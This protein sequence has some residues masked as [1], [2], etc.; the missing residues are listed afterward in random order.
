MNATLNIILTRFRQFVDNHHILQRFSFGQIDTVDLEKFGTYPLLHVVPGQENIDTVCTWSLDI[1][2]LDKPR[3]KDQHSK[4]DYQKHVLSDTAQCMRDLIAEITNGGNVFSFDENWSINVAV[5]AQYITQAFN[6]TLSG[7]FATVEINYPW[8]IDACDLPMT[9]VTPADLDCDDAIVTV[10][11]DAFGSVPSGGTLDVPVEYGDGTPVGTIV[12]GVVVIPPCADGNVEVNGVAYDVVPS[13]GTLDVVV[14]NTLTN[15]VGSLVGGVWQVPDGDITINSTPYDTVPSDATTNVI[16][17]NTL[18]NQVGSIVGSDWQV[19][20]GDITVNSIA[21]SSVP[22]D[23]TAN[24]VV[25]NTLG[26]LVG[27]IVGGDWQIGNASVTNSDASYSGSVAAQGSLTLPDITITNQNG[28]T[29]SFPAAKNLNIQSFKTGILY[30]AP[31]YTQKTSYNTGDEGDNMTNGVYNYTPPLYPDVIQD[32]DYTVTA[33]NVYYTLKSNNVFGNKFRFTNGSGADLSGAGAS[34]IIIDHLYNLMWF[35]TQ[36]GVASSWSNAFT[37]V[38]ASNAA[39]PGGF[40]NWRLPTKG[41][42]WTILEEHN[43]STAF[44]NPFSNLTA[45]IYWTSTTNPAATTQA[46]NVFNGRLI[47]ATAKTTNTYRVALVR[48]YS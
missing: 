7:V 17:E 10:N 21:Y 19:P 42:W 37:I 41:E 34:G 31:L 48:K 32:L 14:E 6:H 44:R 35:G 40:N 16:V 8:G 36:Q 1:Y 15:P 28:A 25:E 4:Q 24:V 11:G 26:T 47:T 5:P 46:L 23:G 22:S 3:D 18:G 38:T 12:S 27:S 45:G 29:S 2:I 13:G 9:G 30:R 20:D 39:N 43:A 33:A